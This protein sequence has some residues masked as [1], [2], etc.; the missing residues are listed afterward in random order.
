LE[1]F[2][3]DGRPGCRS[4]I[5][6]FGGPRK[7]KEGCV[8]LGSCVVICPRGAIRVESGLARVNP[9]LC[10]GCGLCAKAC[11]VGVIDLLPVDQA[12]FVACSNKSEPSARNEVCAAACTACGACANRSLHGEFAIEAGMAREDHDVRSTEW[13]VIAE[14]CPSGAILRAG[15]RK[16]GAS[17]F[18]KTDR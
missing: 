8:G 17:P 10:T 2:P 15:V 18:P 1:D 11:P 9:S 5:E 14:T 4:A 7:C 12:W 13:P 3:F 16:K 6:C